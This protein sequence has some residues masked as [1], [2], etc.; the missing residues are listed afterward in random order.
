MDP[1]SFSD[2]STKIEANLR[3][4]ATDKNGKSVFTSEG[5]QDRWLW[6]HHFRTLAKQR[7]I[8]Y[9]DFGAND[10]IFTSDTFF[11]DHC[12][13]AEGVC[14]EPNP[15]HSKRID[16]IRTCKNVQRCLSDREENV[17]YAYAG[18]NGER[19]PWDTVSG[20]L[21]E[22]FKNKAKAHNYVDMTCT[23]GSAVL[24]EMGI[25]HADWL[26]LDAEGHEL[27][28][29]KGIDFGK[30]Q[31]DIITVEDNDHRVEEYLTKLGYRKSAKVHYDNVFL[32][33]GFELLNPKSPVE[34]DACI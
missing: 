6:N 20:V 1:D 16:A 11:Y 14:V 5:G 23:T 17:T 26:D 28:I 32:R 25:T 13:A 18:E 4:M 3:H 10:A 9:L 21:D 19:N 29:L 24:A 15:K 22:T 8:V 31:I 33:A 34:D 2:T 7:K 30:H 27:K 12:L